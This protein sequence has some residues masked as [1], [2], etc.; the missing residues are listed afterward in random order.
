M[1]VADVDA[2][3]RVWMGMPHGFVTN[4]LR[5]QRRYAGVQGKR[6]ISNRA[7]GEPACGKVSS[8]TRRCS[9]RSLQASMAQGGLAPSPPQQGLNAPVLAPAVLSKVSAVTG[10]WLSQFVRR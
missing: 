3:L 6:S 8:E 7:T 1:K 9:V 5:N 4:I 2:K 10:L